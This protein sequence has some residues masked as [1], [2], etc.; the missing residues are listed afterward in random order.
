MPAKHISTGISNWK[1]A[2]LPELSGKTYVITG[3]NSGIGFEAARILGSK[4]ADII[5]AC[6]NPEKAAAAK[7]ALVPDVRGSLDVLRLD[8]S[9]LRSVKTAAT[10]L[11]QRVSKID[12]LINN[13]GIMMTPQTKTAEGF[14]LQM[15]ANHLGHFLWSGLLLDLVEEASGRIVVTSSLVHKGNPLN[16]DDLMSETRYTPMRAYE[17]SKL[18]NLMFAFELDRRLALSGSPAICVACHPGY[19]DTNLQSTG[20]T[21]FMKMMLAVLNKVAA[22]RREAGA[23]PTALA[24]AGTEAKRGAYYGPRSF[25]ESRGPVGDA[26]VAEHALDEDKQRQL[27]QRSEELTGFRWSLKS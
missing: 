8:L 17:Q 10:E 12:G 18:S 5:M 4:G 19:T 25:G 24:A 7:T 23:I 22:Q 1:A 15:A 21:G 2:Q 11:R 3:A 26:L 16:L 27:W 13:A 6:R 14:D 9:D 20:P